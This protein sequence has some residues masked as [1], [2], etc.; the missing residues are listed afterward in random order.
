MSKADISTTPIRSRRAVLAGIASA[1]A[2]PIAAAI[3]AS[4]NATADPAFALTA[5]KRVA[6]V[7]HCVAIDVQAEAESRYGFS[8]PEA[9]DASERSQEMC[10]RAHEVDWKLATTTPTTLAGVAAVLRFANQIEDEGG[11][12]PGT[13]T[14]GAEGWHYQL[15]AT[16]AQAIEVLINT[17]SSRAV[18]S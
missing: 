4:A 3:P 7:A 16:V 13:D 11:E 18:Q 8:S 2:L 6:D 1:A 14:I 15:R 17:G 9:W 10:W 12:W 5:Q